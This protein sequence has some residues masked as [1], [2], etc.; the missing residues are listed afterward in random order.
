MIKRTGFAET[1]QAALYYE[2][3]ESSA[4]GENAQV[5]GKSVPAGADGPAERTP[6]VMLHGNG[7]DH[8]I[9]DR[10]A[11]IMS[12]K[13][14]VILMDSRGH[15]AS[16][17]RACLKRDGMFTIEDMAGDVIEVLDAL[18]EGKAALLGF[19]DG[20]NIALEAASRFP[21]R[22]TAVAAVS[23]N[24]LPWGVT[25]GFFLTVQ[26]QYPLYWLRERLARSEETKREMR[27]KRQLT[28]L[29]AFCP[30]LMA[31]RL[32]EI[33]CPVLILTGRRDMIRPR[34]SLWMA[35]QIPGAELVFVRGADH[36]TMLKRP[37]AYA[38]HIGRWLESRLQ[39][40]GGLH[41]KER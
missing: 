11:E 3:W 30:R 12:R 41:M 26:A 2:V 6:L 7:E 15:G 5:R 1:A 33:R 16:R 8:H 9:F 25:P 17:P 14:R 20:A 34:H 13:F 19:S 32:G 24:A 39:P 36:F 29:M 22:I 21:D 38:R 28:A 35:E 18:G 40:E 37:A 31:R 27:R 23:G 4:G 10:M